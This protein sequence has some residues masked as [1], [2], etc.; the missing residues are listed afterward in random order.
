MSPAEDHRSEISG[1]DQRR[2]VWTG[3]LPSIARVGVSSG[4]EWSG[5]EWALRRSGGFCIHIPTDLRGERLE[6]RGGFLSA[7]GIRTAC[8]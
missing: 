6:K 7:F 8:V 2:E 1:H 4:V 5:V 3:T